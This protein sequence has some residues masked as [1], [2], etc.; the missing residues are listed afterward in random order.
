M[1]KFL[2]LL[3]LAIETFAY[4]QTISGIVKDKDSFVENASIIIE[5]PN[6]GNILAYA[7]T[8]S[9]GKYSLNT[10]NSGQYKITINALG[11][12]LIEETINFS[13]HNLQKNYTLQKDNA[14]EIKEVIITSSKAISIKKDTIEFNVKSFLQGNERV[15]EDLLKKIPGINVEND[16]TI[17]IGNREVEKVM[18]ENDDFFEKS[19]KLTTKNMPVKPLD[20]IQILENYSNNKHLKNIENSNKVALNLTLKEG[21]KSKWFGNTELSNTI[22]PEN[23]HEAKLNLMNFSKENKFFFLANANNLGYDATGNIENLNRTSGT[24][25]IGV[26]TDDVSLNNLLDT[27][28]TVAGL[29]QSKTN[30]NNDKV[31]SLNSIHNLSKRFKIKLMGFYNYKKNNFYR[32][33]FTEFKLPNQNFKN[34][35]SFDLQKTT[36][37]LFFKTEATYEINKNNTL[38]YSGNMNNA[39]KKNFS[40][41]NLNNINYIEDVFSNYTAINQS[42]KH[43]IK[44]S[45]SAVVVSSINYINEKLPNNYSSNQYFFNGLFPNDDD[46]NGYAQNLKNN[47]NYWGIKSHYIKRFKNGKLIEASITNQT[48]S[49]YFKNT[50]YLNENEV[51]INTPKDFNNDLNFKFSDT[52]LMLKYLMKMKNIEIAP[53]ISSH[54]L[55]NT[56]RTSQKSSDSYFYINPS[57]NFKWQVSDNQRIISLLQYSKTNLETLELL[58]N[59][60]FYGY[61]SFEKGIE[62]PKL[63][64]NS[65][66]SIMY[67]YGDWSD[68]F[69]AN[70][71]VS[72]T[73]YHDYLISYN[74]ISQEYS[75]NNKIIMKNKNDLATKLNVD[76]YI[77]AIKSNL[78]LTGTY[79]FSNYLS[80]A[81]SLS[82]VN[83]KMNNYNF[84]IELRSAWRKLNYHLG[85][86]WNFNHITSASS[87]SVTNNV[88]FLDLNYNI[89]KKLNFQLKTEKYYFGNWS[90]NTKNYYFADFNMLYMMNEKLNFKLQMNNLFNTEYFLDYQLSD[91]YTS[92][93]K[94]RLL[95]RL[96][97]IGA[98][99]SF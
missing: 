5:N 7:Y 12:L 70:L 73:N 13:T 99:Y 3:L 84:G 58:P 67:N 54:F 59:Y 66:A 65:S 91:F 94:Y 86:R 28:P 79:F 9:N 63:L 10:P 2:L 48:R 47:L 50:F 89:N 90:G 26:I 57:L 55:V 44:L 17:K 38:E 39:K 34:T 41:S 18:I 37:N 74:L 77:L 51:A 76:F 46:A 64:G 60:F 30:F 61:R 56:I 98:E 87:S 27:T 45:D 6:N 32:D 19:Y 35:E 83:V 88:S 85:S 31:I 62:N 42:L 16:G 43:S 92:E 29:S 75:L 25:E 11:Y 24:E 4:S 8:D 95:P 14:K 72:Y 40:N 52:E 97:S 81:N 80:G 82:L 22:F 68:K 96:I 23:R 78:K 21:E 36:K 1:K 49:E 69:F 33:T 15:V 20:K 53:Q 93:T 71:M